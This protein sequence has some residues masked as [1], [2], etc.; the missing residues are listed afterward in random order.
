MRRRIGGTRLGRQEL[1]GV[2]FEEVDGALW[3]RAMIEKARVLRDAASTGSAAPQDERMGCCRIVV[4]VDPP[5]SNEGVCGIVV[6][7]LD[8][9]GVGHVL[10]DLSVGGVSPEGWARK[11]AAAAEAWG[12]QRIVAEANNGGRMV[13]TVLRGAGLSLPVKLVHA[14]E[15]KAAR[16]APVATLFES[17]RAKLAGCFPALE[18]ELAGLSWEGGYAGPGRS[19]DRADAMVWALTELMLQPRRA[20]PSIRAL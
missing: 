7:G 8:D 5:A 2:L 14:A 3:P 20:P 11:A 13:E 16:A 9:Q 18:D 15:G 19:P 1:E 12:A 17:G 4:G 6:C 10:A